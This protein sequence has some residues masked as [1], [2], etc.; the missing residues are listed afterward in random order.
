MEPSLTQKAANAHA[1]VDGRRVAPLRIVLA[2]N[3]FK[4]SLTAAEAADAMAA[5]LRDAFPDAELHMAPIADGG[6]GSVDAFVR[7]DYAR[8]P[9]G[10]RGPTGLPVT[11]AIATRGG[12]AVV[13]LA[14]ACGLA[15]LPGG[16]LDPLRSSTLGLGDAVR[17]ALDTGATRIVVCIGGSASTDGGAGLLVALGARLRDVAGAD[18]PPCGAVLG[19]VA[20][21]DLTGLDP[22]LAGVEL[23]VAADVT[24]PLHGPS[25][26]AVVFAPQKGATPDQ[27]AALDSALQ[28][29]GD[30]LE[31]TTG[32]DVAGIAGAGAAGGT[33]AALLALGARLRPG[34]DVVAEA[35]DLDGALARCDVVIT[36]EGRVDAQTALG[37]GV[38]AVVRRATKAGAAAIVVGGQV[39]REAALLLGSVAVVRGLVPD[40]ASDVRVHAAMR[41]AAT[42]LSQATADAL[43]EWLAE[44]PS[45]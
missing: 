7:A 45:R 5:G 11:T 26:A 30:V 17:A 23:L 39:T 16:A 40:G 43:P 18:L 10:V 32:M 25:G 33:G 24:S 44:H 9:V 12:T 34:F 36:G 15:R 2:P 21:L 20:H 22:R 8:G 35:I 37:K 14:D 38:G 4:G 6:D 27:V 29:W 28:H 1:D 41:G 3:A 13:E 31:R 42:L 19:E